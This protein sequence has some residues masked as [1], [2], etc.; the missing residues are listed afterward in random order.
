MRATSRID[1]LILWHVA[2]IVG[3]ACLVVGGASLDSL[4]SMVPSRASDNSRLILDWAFP[5][6]AATA[7]QPG[8]YAQRSA[9]R[10]ILRLLITI[11]I[12]AFAL[13]GAMDLLARCTG[14]D[15]PL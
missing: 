3:L 2:G 9:G 13:W 14:I 15:W 6:L 4:G 1:N 5:Y 10:D 7:R 12:G 11:A 8:L